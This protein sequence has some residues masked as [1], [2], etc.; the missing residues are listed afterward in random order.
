M[1]LVN[2]G[3]PQTVCTV[4]NEDAIIEPVGQEP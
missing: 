3:H 1:T 2:A 4:A